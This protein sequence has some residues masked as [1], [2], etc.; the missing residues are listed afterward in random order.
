MI[1]TTVKDFMKWGDDWVQNGPFFALGALV[2][3]AVAAVVFATYY[4]NVP[5][6][7]FRML[8]PLRQPPAYT[9]YAGPRG[10]T[11]SRLASSI[12]AGHDGSQFTLK[13]VATKGSLDNAVNVSAT[14]RAF[15]FVAEPF[16]AS[17]YQA[18]GPP[19]QRVAPLYMQRAFIAYDKASWQR[20]SAGCGA[21]Q[22][23]LTGDKLSCAYRYLAQARWDA[24]P[25]GG[26]GRLVVNHLL[27]AAD[28]RPR[29]LGHSADFAELAAKLNEGRVD[30]AFYFAGDENDVSAAVSDHRDRLGLAGV[31]PQLA[32]SLRSLELRPSAFID[33]G[34]GQIETLGAYTVLVASAGIPP[35]HVADFVVEAAKFVQ[36]M[37]A[38]AGV[39]S[40][41]ETHLDSVA[42]A[43]QAAG[44]ARKARLWAA[45][46]QF[47]LLAVAFVFLGGGLSSS[48]GARRTREA[49]MKR[50]S[51]LLQRVRDC[52]RQRNR[53][54]RAAETARAL[55]GVENELEGCID[56][57]QRHAIQGRLP[58]P[59]RDQLMASSVTVRSELDRERQF[60]SW[61]ER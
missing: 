48:R 57:I 55:D 53:V 41:G 21:G 29:V 19:L 2:G 13:M 31:D 15:A 28:L 7:D 33:E 14:R 22:L 3:V 58:M 34:G 59:Y 27:H 60:H 6:R 10:G 9:L 24:G 4:Q 51:E 25:T 26:G 12:I 38:P 5:E 40:T 45:A 16:V 18:E 30:V 61:T 23:Q 46:A 11:Y 44:S 32:I 8:W 42:E 39:G 37:S 47:L 54:D 20:F 1:P 49:I 36:N 50:Q 35:E 52:R 43:L 17:L 56:D